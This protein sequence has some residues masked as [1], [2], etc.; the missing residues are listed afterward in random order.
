IIQADLFSMAELDSLLERE[1]RYEHLKAKNQVVISFL[2]YQGLLPGEIVNLKLHHVDL[3]SGSVYVNAGRLLTARRLPLL[4]RQEEILS[5]YIHTHRKRMQLKGENE[6]LLLNFQGSPLRVDDV[7]YL[8]Q[9][10][11][12]RF[13]GRNLNCKSIRDSVISYWM[14]TKKIP[15]EQVQLLAGHRW[16]SSTLRYK[17]IRIKEIRETL[18]KIFPLEKKNT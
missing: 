5:E 15:P 10:M 9:T 16:I 13:P 8:V 3:D 6:F 18:N 2:I 11:K 7:N 14:N 12:D 4:E 17:Q 1:E